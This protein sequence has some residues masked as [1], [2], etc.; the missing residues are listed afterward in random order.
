MLGL[1]TAVDQFRLDCK[2]SEF[3]LDF[4]LGVTLEVL[5][6]LI[7]APQLGFTE[8]LYD[9]TLDWDLND[10]WWGKEEVVGLGVLVGCFGMDVEFY[11]ELVD[12]G[13]G[14]DHLVEVLQQLSIPSVLF[15][16]LSV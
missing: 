1:G 15:G 14:A 3:L 13:R 7:A 11:W 12:Y 8:F 5:E 9:L 6:G 10:A 2:L 16:Q 4:L